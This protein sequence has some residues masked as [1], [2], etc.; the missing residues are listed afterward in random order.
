M[1]CPTLE[2]ARKN[3][4]QD[5]VAGARYSSQLL[6]VVHGNSVRVDGIYVSCAESPFINFFLS[7]MTF[8]GMQTTSPLPKRRSLQTHLWN[9]DW[10]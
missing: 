6:D 1:T 7:L 10:I 2:H 9:V 4:T 8:I 5:G 3:L